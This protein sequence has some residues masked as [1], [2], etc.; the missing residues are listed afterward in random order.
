MRP[1]TRPLEAGVAGW[2]ASLVIAHGDR[3]T[4]SQLC[5][6][7][8]AKTISRQ[9]ALA[10]HNVPPELLQQITQD[11]ETRRQGDEESPES[12]PSVSPLPSPLSSIACATCHREHHGATVRPDGDGQRG[13]PV[14]PP[15][16][17]RELCDGSSGFRQLAV[18]A[19]DADCVQSCVASRQA[20]CGEEAGV[21]LPDVP[22]RRSRQRSVQLLGQLRSDVRGVPRRED[23]DERGPRRADVGAADAGCR[24]AAGRRPRHW[25]LAE[26][27]RRAIS[28][29]DCRR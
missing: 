13:V 1:A 19:A 17:V 9:L 22:R 28:T 6:K 23:R 25:P 5:M 12:H 10:A 4:Q 8:H 16:A 11:W 14:V 24:R 29:A 2:T 7:C 18:R 26:Q 21:R 20:L 27:A 15:A 3:P